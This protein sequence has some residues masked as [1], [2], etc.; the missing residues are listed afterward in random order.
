MALSPQAAVSAL[1]TT[2]IPVSHSFLISTP[3]SF[4]PHPS[5]SSCSSVVPLS[6]L[7]PLLCCHFISIFLLSCL[8]SSTFP[9]SLPSL[10]SVHCLS[11]NSHF[12]LTH[13]TLPPPLLLSC[14][15][16][17]LSSNFPPSPCFQLASTST[18]ILTSLLP[19]LLPSSLLSILFLHWTVAL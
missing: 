11:L 4:T 15:T 17:T 10:H 6:C 14:V 9:L 7:P 3:A 8:S 18:A 5:H 16:Y 13:A 12:S 19:P 2:G 1:E